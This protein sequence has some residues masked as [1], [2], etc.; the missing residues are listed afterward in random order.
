MVK[1]GLGRGFDSLIPTDFSAE[2]FAVD[3]EKTGELREISLGDIFANPDQPRK[4]FAKS[5]LDELAESIREHGILQ[6]LVLV[7]AKNGKYEIVAGERRFRAAKLAGLAKVPAIIRTL[8]EQH[9]AELSIIENVQRADLNPLEVANS[10]AKLR[11]DF[12]LSNAEIAKKV[13]KNP[14]SVANVLRLVELPDF[15]KK[16]LE[17]GEI[18]EGH[19]RQILSLPD[20]KSRK[21]LLAEI[22]ENGWSVRKAEQF[23]LGFKDEIASEKSGKTGK[24][25]VAK[26]AKNA[27]KSHT[28]L[29][30]EISRKIFGAV[31]G[32]EKKVSQKITAHGGEI[33]IKFVD[34]QELLKIREIF[35]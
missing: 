20:E 13:G 27:V 6:P 32:A 8:S 30:N 4:K 2:E 22:R 11:A 9:K 34:E 28:E 10:F 7:P 17:E 21:S 14:S 18:T 29:T 1:R 26:S 5:A 19:A 25:S 24:K 35:K 33:R 15:A 16:S 3:S 23:V 12:G 31:A